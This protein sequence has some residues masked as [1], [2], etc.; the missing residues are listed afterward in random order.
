MWDDNGF[1]QCLAWVQAESYFGVTIRK[2]FLPDCHVAAS[3]GGFIDFLQFSAVPMSSSFALT[4]KFGDR[5]SMHP[6][7]TWGDIGVQ[8]QVDWLS[9][10]SQAFEVILVC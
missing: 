2:D 7:M 1:V 3:A 8:G 6:C 10:S 9:Y 5:Y 4:F